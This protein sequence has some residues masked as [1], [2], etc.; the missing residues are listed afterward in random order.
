VRTLRAVAQQLGLGKAAYRV[1]HQPFGLLRRSIA[2]GGPLEQHRTA[3]GRREM[4][5]AAAQLPTLVEPPLGP[6]AEVAILS[7][8]KYWHETLFCFFSLQQVSSFRITPI[9]FD[10]GSL[11]GEFRAHL[12]R[13]IPWVRFVDAE[14]S[15]T[16][17]DRLIPDRMFPT[18]RARRREYPHLRKLTDIH[19]AANGFTLVLDS[20]ML[21]FREPIALLEWFAAPRALYMR[22]ISTAYGYPRAFLAELVGTC[23]PE[24]VNVGLYSLDGSNLDWER[25]EHWCRRQIEL[26]GPHYFQEQALTAMAL[27]GSDAVALP[28]SDYIVMPGLAEGR[29]PT[30]VLHHYVMQSKRSFYQYG[31]R[32]ISNR[33]KLGAM[34]VHG[35]IGKVTSRDL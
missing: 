22:D 27:A 10:D 33:A 2:A 32:L 20:D 23:V 4:L 34:Q 8:S 11:T 15:E 13:V 5:C 31:W 17:L 16:R 30:A 1:Y 28:S 18:L 7:G 3:I 21:F 12:S 24:S 26:Y 19:V 14:E 29:H 6:D 9:V 25:I 35:E